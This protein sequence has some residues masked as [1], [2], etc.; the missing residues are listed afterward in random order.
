MAKFGGTSIGNSERIKKAANSVVKEY[1][2]GKKIIVVVSAINK[3]TDDLIKIMEETAGDA[4]TEKQRA[5]ITSMGERTSAR[6][7]SSTIESL[8][9]KSEY[10]E[11]N[12]DNWPIITN[13]NFICATVDFKSTE[14]KSKELL[15]L[16]DQGIIPV[17]CGYIAK[18]II[19]NH[20]TTL[21]R[22]G[23]DITAFLLGHCLNA[24]NV[25]IVTDVEGVMSTDPN[26]VDDAQKLDQISVEEMR[27]LATHGAQ[28]LHPHALK[29]KDPDINAKIISFENGDLSSLGTKIVGPLTDET[30]EPSVIMTG[31]LS[32]I[33]VVGE[34]ILLKPGVLEELLKTI[35]SSDFNIYGVS[36]G[37]NSITLFLNKNNAEVAHKLLHDIVLK[38]M[39]LTSL[40]LGEDVAMISINS[41]EFID[42]PGI[43]S[44]ITKPLR[45]HINIVE[46][47]SSQTSVMLFVAW[48]DGEK[49]YEL[50]RSV[51]K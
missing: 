24:D 41:P 27:D 4:T 17:V 25:I 7:M 32:A 38:N 39:N 47:S 2:K 50:I 28:V 20:V 33:S 49:A 26:K 3:T 43:I 29:Y 36:S 34:N 10:I 45:E 44:N 31:P 35:S 12:M 51:L 21:G 11:P 19:S 48:E 5:D 23:S 37:Q 6:I 14:K 40:S 22:G 16:L 18:D 13:E 42:T 1:M 46:I 9:V 15:K 30:N 8:G